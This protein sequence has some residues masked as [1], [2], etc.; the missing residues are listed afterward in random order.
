M[1]RILGQLRRWPRS[2]FSK[3]KQCSEGTRRAARSNTRV[4]FSSLNKLGPSVSCWGCEFGKMG[5][6]LWPFLREGPYPYVGVGDMV[7]T[8]LIVMVVA[9]MVIEEKDKGLGKN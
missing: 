8:V 7:A 4:K 2:R 3:T 6:G 5:E 1:F 9:G